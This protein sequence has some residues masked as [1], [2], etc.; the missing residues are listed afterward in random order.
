MAKGLITSRDIDL[1]KPDRYDST[2]IADVMVPRK[3]INLYPQFAS[4]HDCRRKA[5]C[6]RRTSH[7]RSGLQDLGRGKTRY[8]SSIFSIM[9]TFIPAGKL[10]IVNERNELIALIARTDIKKARD[11]PLSS[12]D[13]RGQLMVG[14][15][16]NTRETA[17]Q[18]VKQL[19]QAEVD[20]LVIVSWVCCYAFIR[21]RLCRTRPMVPAAIKSTCSSGSKPHIQSCK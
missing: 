13:S 18:N 17:K 12:Y 9:S 7:S 3:K 14:A 21:G 2:T 16:V 8:Q 5:D 4:A 20:V 19:V 10:P 11:F 1:I 6:G 15:A